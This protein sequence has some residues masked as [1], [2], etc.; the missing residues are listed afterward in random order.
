MKT[1]VSFGVRGV[2]KSN[3]WQGVVW[4][5]LEKALQNAT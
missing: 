2:A 5:I 4:I 1:D 3:S